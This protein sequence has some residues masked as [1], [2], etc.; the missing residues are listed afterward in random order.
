MDN[1]NAGYTRQALY[2]AAITAGVAAWR[3]GLVVKEVLEAAGYTKYVAEGVH[4]YISTD[5]DTAAREAD[6]YGTT[7]TTMSSQSKK[8]FRPSQTTS[9]Q[10]T[11]KVA[12]KVKKYVKNCM[13]RLIEKKFLY[14]SCNATNM[15]TG[16]TVLASFL[17]QIIQGTTDATRTGNQV[18][19]KRIAI[20]GWNSTSVAANTRL[21]AFWDRQPNGGSP[22]VTD[23][24]QA[25]DVNALY[26]NNY[27]SGWG[28]SRFEIVYDKRLKIEPVIVAQGDYQYF[29]IL[30]KKEKTVVYKGNAAAVADMAT[31]NFVVIAIS[32]EATADLTAN[33]LIE[34]EDI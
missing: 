33:I 11:A 1:P 21:I 13:N 23:V 6:S 4:N 27:V 8:R 15:G 12:P 2:G 17:C 7:T 22:S 18:R 14:A 3:A 32:D 26:N 30:S 10:T 16:G 20:K 29:S 19:C 31:N 28:G 34:F 5:P 25:A 24:L 9:S